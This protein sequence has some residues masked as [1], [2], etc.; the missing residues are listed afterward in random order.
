MVQ[1]FIL[2]FFSIK[3]THGYEIQRFISLN[4]MS[5]WNNI[6][7]GSIY[8]AIK[9]LE[10]DGYIR[11]IDKPEEGEK[12]KQ[13][14]EITQRG[15]DVLKKLAYNEMSKPL[16]GAASEKFL[17][18]PIIANLQKEEIIQCVEKHIIDLKAQKIRIDDWRKEKGQKA[19]SMEVITLDYMITTVDSQIIWHNMMLENLDN[20]IQESKEIVKLIKETDFMKYE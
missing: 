14:Y 5:E 15:R 6:K 2:F 12:K 13:I 4:R 9:K 20:I 3:P 7:S 17:L 19:C 8:Y 11:M 18:Y 10:K 16:Q 1:L